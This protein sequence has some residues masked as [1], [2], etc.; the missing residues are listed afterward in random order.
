MYQDTYLNEL[1]QKFGRAD[2]TDSELMELVNI[3]ADSGERI[4]MPESVFDFAS[5]GGP[6]SLSTLLVPLF[7]FG[8]G[9]S[10]V[11]LAVSGRPA[12]AVDVLAQIPRYTLNDL[13]CI[14]KLKRP[15]YIHLAANER[16][17]PLDRALFEYR[18]ENNKVDIPN[19]VVSSI[20]AKKL[21]SGA[22]IIG[23]DVRVS[24]FGNFGKNIYESRQ[25][26]IKYNRI[27]SLLGLK[28][29]CFISNSNYPYQN[30]IGRGEALLALHKIFTNQSDKLL[31]DHVLYCNR[32]ANIMIENSGINMNNSNTCSLQES[33]VYN[34]ES[35][36]SSYDEFEKSVERIEHATRYTVLADTNGYIQYDLHL[37]RSIIVRFQNE[38][39]GNQTF[40]DP[41]G[42]ILL[43]NT[44]DYV[45]C[46]QPVLSVRIADSN[47][48]ELFK[49]SII[50]S[51]ELNAVER[52]YEVI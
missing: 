18:K 8:R 16:F 52:E 46:G 6:S 38:C 13:P 32:M 24:R 28:S 25:N 36:G 33:F 30:Y 20:L 7:L 39:G 49:Q 43:C 14:T 23:L 12:G 26:C 34:L 29:T 1:V 37:I 48:A 11:D 45:S 27:A 10:V 3:L 47:Q 35:Q 9:V 15:F 44:Y 5:T 22:E 19:L 4:T 41:C 50:I 40:P 17:T 51:N 31:N 42:V 2:A 21:A